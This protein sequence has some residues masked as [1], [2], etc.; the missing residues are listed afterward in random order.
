MSQSTSARSRSCSPPPLTK[1][2]STTTILTLEQ[3]LSDRDIAEVFATN[4]SAA[5]LATLGGVSRAL[6]EAVSEKQLWV[7]QLLARFAVDPATLANISEPRR[8]FAR[9][10]VCASVDT[11]AA[12]TPAISKLPSPPSTPTT[13]EVAPRRWA[14]RL[15]LAGTPVSQSWSPEGSPPEHDAEN[16]E[17]GSSYRR[18]LR[19]LGQMS[20]SGSTTGREAVVDISEE[21]PPVTRSASQEKAARKAMVVARLR[22]GLHA[23][24][25]GGNSNLTAC[26]EA[27]D[28]WSRWRAKVTACPPQHE[29]SLIGGGM[30]F[31]FQ[32][33]YPMGDEEGFVPPSLHD[34]SDHAHEAALPRISIAS[35]AAFFHPNVN[36]RTGALCVKALGRRCTPVELVGEQLKA[37]LSVLARP[38]FDVPPLNAKA[39]REWYGDRDKLRRFVRGRDKPTPMRRIVSL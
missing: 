7:S 21:E 31:D 18:V 1:I 5:A 32:L 37:A 8:E 22:A 30:A 2:T 28:D 10:A 39:A 12:S 26:P 33:T 4:A 23:V 24:V 20:L 16:R 29:G 35:P 15:A 34:G 17:N 25:M 9:R 11:A 6:K 19:S 13:E 36:P 38:V 14:E 3:L 27:P